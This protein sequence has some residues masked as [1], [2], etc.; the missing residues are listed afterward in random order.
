[1]KFMTDLDILLIELTRKL[2]GVLT[3]FTGL[4]TYN[5]SPNPS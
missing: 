5:T 3:R 4:L 2:N 1:M